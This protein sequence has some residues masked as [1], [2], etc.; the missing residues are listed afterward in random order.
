MPIPKTIHQIWYSEKPMPEVFLPLID[1]WREFNPNYNYILWKKCE[2]DDLIRN[3]YSDKQS[4]F[5]DVLYDIQKVDIAR[6]LILDYTGGVYIDLDYE[7]LKPIDDLINKKNLCLV[8]EPKDHGKVDDQQVIGNAFM[9]SEKMHPLVRLLIKNVFARLQ[10][11]VCLQ[12]AELHDKFLYVL[13]S[14]GPYLLTKVLKAF[15]LNSDFSANDIH[16]LPSHILNPLSKKEAFE[17]INGKNCPN[18]LA[19]TQGSYGIHYFVG[20]WLSEL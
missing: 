15:E 7:C 8:L 17:Y 4:I 2:V 10:K 13:N 11:R 1:S 16:L 18:L 6:Y 14:T 19:K 5:N 3:H 9:A 12:D 20:S